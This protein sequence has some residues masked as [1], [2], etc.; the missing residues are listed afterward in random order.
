MLFHYAE[1]S[2]HFASYAT[3]EKKR[4]S[5]RGTEENISELAATRLW[6]SQTSFV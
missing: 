5:Q 4:S 1:F 2:K 6:K 3:A